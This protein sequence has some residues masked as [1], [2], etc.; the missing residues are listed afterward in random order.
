MLPT[1]QACV[2]CVL[3]TVQA[4]VG[5]VV[6]TKRV[7][8][9]V[10]VPTAQAGVFCLLPSVQSG[11]DSVLPTLKLLWAVYLLR[12]LVWAV[13][14]AYCSGCGG[15]CACLLYRFGWAV[16]CTVRLV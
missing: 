2:G 6:P 12:G 8:W 16:C 4:G 9:A 14:A 7:L 11:F 1:V 13:C 10:Y 15:F 5:S 3:P